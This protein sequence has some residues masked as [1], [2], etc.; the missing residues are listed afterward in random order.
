MF[1]GV[2][3]LRDHSP[4]HLG[5]DSPISL[6][7]FSLS[8]HNCCNMVLA[9]RIKDESNPSRSK[10]DENSESKLRL[11][12]GCTLLFIVSWEF[13]SVAFHSNRKVTF[14]SNM[15][16]LNSKVER[17]SSASGRTSGTSL[18]LH[19][20]LHLPI[21]RWFEMRT[22]SSWRVGKGTRHSST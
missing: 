5:C 6:P 14:G 9:G 8:R 13:S 11:I 18:W 10:I 1:S 4:Q 15:K 12:H 17:A 22:L 2:P 20:H 16:L 21:W 7:W 3:L 19:I